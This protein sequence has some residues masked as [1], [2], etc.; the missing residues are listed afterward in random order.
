MSR[1]YVRKR[2]GYTVVWNDLFESGLSNA[3]I[4][5]LVRMLSKTDDYSFAA[6][7]IARECKEGRGAILSQ[8]RELEDAGYLWRPRVRSSTGRV[9]TLVF[10]AD[11]P[12]YKGRQEEI[13]EAEA[14]AEKGSTGVEIPDSGP[15][16]ASV[17]TENKEDQEQTSSARPAPRGKIQDEVVRIKEKA[18]A[19]TLRKSAKPAGRDVAPAVRAYDRARDRP[20]P[21]A[22][23]PAQRCYGIAHRFREQALATFPDEAMQASTDGVYKT[24]RRILTES[25]GLTWEHLD[26]ASELF[27]EDTARLHRPGV[28]AWKN[29]LH[30]IPQ[31]VETARRELT[32]AISP[33]EWLA[34]RGT[35]RGPLSEEEIEKWAQGR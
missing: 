7:R 15:L 26:R 23:T 25:P 24:L 2:K 3:A 18:E 29:F 4:G 27:F 31:L 17:T 28:P 11:S 6:D 32:P 34:G 33:E 1:L 35:T 30:H 16:D 21:K 20:K 10:L 14:D 9:V 13:T 8:L 19:G 22:V 12:V 5:L